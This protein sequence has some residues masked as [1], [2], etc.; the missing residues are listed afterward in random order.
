M[1]IP[2]SIR[3]LA[4]AALV[5]AVLGTC[6]AAGLFAPAQR[7]ASDALLDTTSADNK[8]ALLH[9]LQALFK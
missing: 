6:S 2:Y 7:F 1:R 4:P 3:V 5:T 9:Q 8:S